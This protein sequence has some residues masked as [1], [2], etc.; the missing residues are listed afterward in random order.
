MTEEKANRASAL[1]YEIAC[2]KDCIVSLKEAREAKMT[3]LDPTKPGP[4]DHVLETLGRK[5]SRFGKKCIDFFIKAMDEEIADEESHL[6]GLMK[7]LEE[8]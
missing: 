7:E 5:W 1:L 6:A 3:G 8:L 4:R 2:T